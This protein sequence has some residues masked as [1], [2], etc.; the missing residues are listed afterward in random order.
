MNNY[1]QLVKSFFNRNQISY[2][3]LY[4]TNRCNFKCDFCFYYAEIEKGQRIDELT[5]EEIR[6]ISENIGPLVQLSIT[7][8][9]PFLC[10]DLAEITGFFIKNNFVKYI[11]IPTNASL[12]KRMVEY[13]ER[14]LPKYP[15]TYFR[16]PFSID[17]IGE[18]HDRYRSAPGSYKKIQKSYQAIGSLRKKYHNLILD[19]N[20]IFTSDSQA[21]ILETIKTIY[22]CFDFDNVSITYIRGDV[23]NQALKKPSFQKYLEVNDYLESLRRKKEKRFLYP[24]WR[25]VR[26]VSR[27]YLIRTV[28]D[29]KFITPCTAGRKLL[30]ISESGE[31]YPC[32][33]L[34][35]SMGNVRDFNFDIKKLISNSENQKLFKWIKDSKCKC[36]FECALAA[37]VLWGKS[38]YFKLLKSA[39]K[40][41]GK[42]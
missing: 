21:T 39:V 7:G 24:L 17:G 18:A 27:E 23:K 22:Q 8:G 36:G 12:T 19:S 1:I 9:E 29:D 37:N 30:I 20:T 14:V 16:I 3:I 15:H 4:V 40:N 28:L 31:V 25:A 35:R 41:I 42:S 26:D 11:T 38:S 34:K 10:E 13:L 6:K 2:L 33:I 5:L 32:E